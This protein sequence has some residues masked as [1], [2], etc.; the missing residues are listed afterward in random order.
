MEI[1]RYRLDDRGSIPGR[2]NDAIFLN[3]PPLPDRLCSPTSL[4]S[5]RYRGLLHQGKVDRALS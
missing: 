1:L 4:L 2:G 5:N 3:S